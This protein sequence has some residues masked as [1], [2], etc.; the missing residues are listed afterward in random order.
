[1]VDTTRLRKIN[2]VGDVSIKIIIAVVFVLL[3]G[4]I[5]YNNYSSY[6]SRKSAEARRVETQAIQADLAQQPQSKPKVVPS[7]TVVSVPT[8]SQPQDTAIDT[9]PV[10]S[11]SELFDVNPTPVVS[12]KQQ[13]V[14]DKAKMDDALLRWNDALKVAASTPRIHLTQEIKNLQAIK[15]EVINMDIAP[16]M[17]ASK[18]H[19]AN[20]MTIFIDGLLEFK[21]NTIIGEFLFRDYAKKAN[22]D[23]ERYSIISNQCITMS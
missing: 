2:W 10:A 23:M 12:G 3:V 9:M 15:L 7:A 19:L 8:A 5:S 20:A 11:D 21:S 1:M 17:T 4:L 18:T 13:M 6:Q 22:R 16:C 14:A